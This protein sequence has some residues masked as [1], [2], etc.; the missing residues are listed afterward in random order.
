MLG[1]GEV[2]PRLRP[3]RFGASADSK[4]PSTLPSSGGNAGTASVADRHT[5]VGQ[6]RPHAVFDVASY[7]PHLPERRA[8]RVADA[9]V[10]VVDVWRYVDYADAM[11][12]RDD[13][14]RSLQDLVRY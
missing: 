10:F 12:H 13:H 5:E 11:T 9:P 14:V 6:Q 3:R 4:R 8:D 2:K 7:A 1:W